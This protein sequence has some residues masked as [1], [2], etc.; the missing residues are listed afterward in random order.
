MLETVLAFTRALFEDL[1]PKTFQRRFLDGLL[2]IQNVERGSLWVRRNGVIA[3]IEAAG[4][5]SERILGVELPADKPSVVG[6]VMDNARMTIAEPGKDPRHYKAMEDGLAAKSTLIL[7]YPLILRD[8]TVYGAVELI[9]TAAR[10]GRLNLRKDYL[11]LL[12][13][14][15][16]VGSVALGQALAF[17][18]KERECR[19]LKNALERFKGQPPIVGHSSAVR[20]AMKKVYSYARTDFPVLIT[21]ESGTGK[22]LFAQAI[23]QASPRKDKPFFVQNCS[24]I[25]ETLLE[26]ELFGYRK[27]A[28]T[29]ADR[30]KTGLFEAAE[31]GTVFLDEIGDMAP[32]LQAK[33]LRLIQNSE[34]KPLGGAA[35]RTVDVRIISATNKD[36]PKAIED[37]EFREDLF[38]RLNVLPLALPPLRERSEDVPELLDYFIKRDCLRLGLGA[39]RLSAQASARLSGYSWRGNIREMENLVKYILTVV[40]GEL[41]EERDLPGHITGDAGSA[42]RGGE[43]VGQDASEL[44]AM[45]WDELERRYTLD[46][47]EKY[48]WNVTRAAKHAGV[49]RSTFDSRLKKLGISKG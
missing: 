9:D 12:E 37:G 7:C 30:D 3:C 38:Y 17:E 25:P 39:K 21:G 48:R 23:H 15:V 47:L 14:L 49:N 42:A 46:I 8:G 33:I 43:G 35:T 11:E 36:L 44:C 18:S 4:E 13:Y 29:G 27:G 24:A 40:E 28:F 6:W 16:A 41:I 45:T 10:G 34:V 32:P 20:E 26:S 31:G 5:E 1:D 19:G 22:E 2:A